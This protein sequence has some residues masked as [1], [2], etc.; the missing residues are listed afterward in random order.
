[1]RAA[2]M[3]M[4]REKSQTWALRGTSLSRLLLTTHY[5]DRSKSL[6]RMEPTAMALRHQAAY[7]VNASTSFS[8]FAN[9]SAGVSRPC[10]ANTMWRLTALP[11]A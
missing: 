6:Y 1:M 8:A 10:R 5:R 2:F 9:A 4:G 7:W 11:I 3:L